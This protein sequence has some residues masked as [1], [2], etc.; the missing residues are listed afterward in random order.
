MV[1]G[2]WTA[3]QVI[4]PSTGKH[5]GGPLSEIPFTDTKAYI[6]LT[7]FAINLIV[8]VVLTIAFR[9]L[10]VADGKDETHPT[11]YRADAGDPGVKDLSEL[12]DEGPEPARS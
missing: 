4:N 10:N 6:A 3:Y 8:V 11:D 7:A 2:T 9:A 5:F 12:L 1:Y